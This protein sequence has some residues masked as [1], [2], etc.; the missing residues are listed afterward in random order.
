[1]QQDGKVMAAGGYDSSGLTQSSTELYDPA[2][3]LWTATGAMIAARYFHT[4]TL[5]PS[6]NVLLVGGANDDSSLASAEL[7]VP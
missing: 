3:G 2:S 5:L 6:G 1:M 7:H 4:A